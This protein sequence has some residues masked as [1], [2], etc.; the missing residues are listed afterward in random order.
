LTAERYA[1]NISV[2]RGSLEHYNGYTYGIVSLEKELVL[3]YE[4][5]IL[6]H[7]SLPE[8][9]SWT[10]SSATAPMRGGIVKSIARLTGHNYI[11]GHSMNGNW[12]QEGPVLFTGYGDQRFGTQTWTFS[13]ISN[14]ADT[15]RLYW[16]GKMTPQRFR[17][18][19]NSD[20]IPIGGA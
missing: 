4:C 15:K 2:G 1:E 18:M 13:L 20:I 8:L 9:P 12:Y 7:A 17:N 5:C 10:T 6:P 19:S 11:L 14:A 3:D 16:V